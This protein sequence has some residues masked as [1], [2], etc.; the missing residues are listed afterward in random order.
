MSR[1]CNWIRRNWSALA[2]LIACAAIL[3]PA[4]ANVV[5]LEV[6][7][8]GLI[9][10]GKPFG[11]VGPYERIAGRLYFE[12]G[13][14]APENQS[15]TDIRLTKRDGRGNIHFSADFVLLQP[16][17]AERGNKRL[18][19]EPA[20][21]HGAGLLATFNDAPPGQGPTKDLDPG[22]GFL[23]EQGYT[24]LWTGWSWDV[25]P[26]DGRL[27]ADLPVAA[28]GEDTIYGRV[29][30]EIAA[31]D[32]NFA[33]RQ[34]PPR[35]IGYTPLRPGDRDARMYSRHSPL[36]PTTAIARDSWRFGRNVDDH[37]IYDP[38][39]ITLDGGFEPGSLYTVTYFARAP[40]V[41]GLGLVGIRDAL[42]FFRTRRA[43]DNNTPNPLLET[44]ASLP[45]AVIAFGKDQSGH[46]L[47]TMIEYGLVNDGLRRKAFEGAIIDGVGAGRG[48]INTRFAQPARIPASD[49]DV[50]SPSYLFPFAPA[51]QSD[52]LTGRSASSLDNL[53]GSLPK[54]FY[55][56]SS[57]EYWS[58]AAALTHTSLDGKT[59]LTPPDEIRQF[60]I[61]GGRLRDGSTLDQR[62]LSNCRSPLDS[63]PLLR[64]LLIRLDAWVTLG[65]APP[66]SRVPKS[67]DGSLVTFD[68]YISGFPNVPGERKPSN[69]FTPPRLNPGERFEA[70]GIADIV[71]ARAVGIYD[72]LVPASNSDGLVSGGLRLPDIA[73][74]L[75]TYTGWNLHDAA[76]GAPER[77]SRFDGGFVPFPRDENERLARED[78]RTSIEERYE[79]RNAY[80]EAYAA[81]ALELA[82]Q[83]L[84]LSEDINPMVERA[85]N[86]YDRIM[87]RDPS[88][89]TCSYLPPN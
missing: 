58:R 2:V 89:E 66:E 83:N 20:N 81:A 15:V 19:Y 30:N 5:R 74:P 67:E 68:A 40:H 56:N 78:P 60:M 47:K 86:F 42:I 63:R 37:L 12:T 18:L 16:A 3:Q 62:N 4:F 54:L 48:D 9:A 14:T 82:A 36:G 1:R 77:L 23:M 46:A 38:A 55:V 8:R 51:Q 49:I 17:D 72:T 85:G 88:D 59:D 29:A 65:E 11:N 25:T 61:A 73:L 84:L 22:N 26:D 34:F 6:L 32:S 10:D 75:G 43:D 69:V 57:T 27:R 21:I 76:T 52:P 41:S 79:S 33:D 64:A 50:H 28:A 80:R 53:S 71:P 35:S 45:E 39:L 31:Y 44:G 13:A 7:E 24:L 70:Q 87:S